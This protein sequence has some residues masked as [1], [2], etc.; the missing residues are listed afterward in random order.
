MWKVKRQVVQTHI[1]EKSKNIWT[2]AHISMYTGLR[3]KLC[4]HMS[5]GLKVTYNNKHVFFRDDVG[6]SK[7]NISPWGIKSLQ[8]DREGHKYVIKHVW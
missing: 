5:M 4:V 7:Y 1:N 6:T 2:Y 3:S 8:R